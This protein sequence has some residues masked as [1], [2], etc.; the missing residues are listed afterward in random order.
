MK[1]ATYRAELNTAL[2]IL[3]VITVGFVIFLLSVIYI[4][5]ELTKNEIIKVAAIGDSITQGV[6]VEG[7]TKIQSYPAQL[8]ALLGSKYE[9]SN[10]GLGGRSLLSTGNLPYIKEAYYKQS[11]AS[12]PN[13]VLIMLGTN[14]SGRNNWNAAL[15]EKELTQFIAVYKSLPSK[16]KVYVLT[17]PAAHID[18]DGPIAES[19]SGVIIKTE[20]VP[21]IIRVAKKTR[22]A[23]IDIYTA[24]KNH[25]DLFPDGI[26]PNTEGYGIIAKTVYEIIQ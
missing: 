13:I 8:Q 7:D 4:P 6:G 11:Q 5:Y 21:A 15:Y 22:T 12:N 2:G 23:V 16:P 20:V 14:D 26:H 18:E 25:L 3:I 17:V 10:Y 19:V 9:V 1:L 24:T